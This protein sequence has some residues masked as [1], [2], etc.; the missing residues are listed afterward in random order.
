MRDELSARSPP[1]SYF[2]NYYSR[3]PSIFVLESVNEIKLKQHIL[4]IHILYIHPRKLRH[5]F[6]SQAQI[7]KHT[8]TRNHT[9]TRTSSDIHL[10]LTTDAGV[11]NP[12]H[13][14]TTCSRV[15]I[16]IARVG[17]N[18]NDALREPSFALLHRACLIST[19]DGLFCRSGA[20]TLGTCVHVTSMLWY[21]GYAR[22]QPV[23]RYPKH[24]LINTIEDAGNRP[25][26]QRKDSEKSDD[27]MSINSLEWSEYETDCSHTNEENDNFDAGHEC[28]SKIADSKTI[29][30]I[31]EKHRLCRTSACLGER[32]IQ[33]PGEVLTSAV[34]VTWCT[35]STG[36]NQALSAHLL[37]PLGKKRSW[38]SFNQRCIGDLVHQ[39]DGTQ[40]STFCSPFTTPRKK[41]SW[42]SFNQR[43]IG[44]LVHQVDGKWFSPFHSRTRTFE[45]LHKF[46]M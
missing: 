39:V 42:R 14:C 36:R 3:V 35:R 20:R 16:V 15:L 5:T 31:T 27:Q 1:S 2:I 32:L 17:L 23:V 4:Y 12:M 38:R 13:G 26:M 11:A 18:L 10:H 22:R 24:T 19:L 43:C 44:D 29:Y 25:P 30:I 46:W 7:N 37:Q 8:L 28:S 40:S 33:D 41:R 21:L 45:A 9:Y 6:Q 34:S